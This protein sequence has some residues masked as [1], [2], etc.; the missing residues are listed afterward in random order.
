MSSPVVSRGIFTQLPRSSV[1]G[2]LPSGQARSMPAPVQGK[3]RSV[4]AADL[5]R[6]FRRRACAKARRG[7][8][9]HS[10]V[11]VAGIGQVE[12]IIEVDPHGL[13]RFERSQEP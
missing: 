3:G 2:I 9:R 7:R 5:E 6:D 1:P 11:V 13:E 12:R 4:A 8:E 10:D